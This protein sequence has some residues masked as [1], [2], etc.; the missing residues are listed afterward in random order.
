MD[1]KT[2]NIAGSSIGFSKMLVQPA[3]DELVKVIPKGKVM[4]DHLSNN[5]ERWEELK[6]E[7]EKKKNDGENYIE[8]SRGIIKDYDSGKLP[9]VRGDP[10]LKNGNNLLPPPL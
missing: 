4:L 2:V 6:D 7:F 9:S 3:Y 5:I 1:R 10:A 8:E